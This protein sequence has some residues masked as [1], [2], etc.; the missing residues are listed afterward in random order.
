MNLRSGRASHLA[1][2]ALI[3]LSA[4]AALAYALSPGH[5][6]VTNCCV[7][8]DCSWSSGLVLA[9]LSLCLAGVAL[10]KVA[11]AVRLLALALSLIGLTGVLELVSFRIE[12]GRDGLLVR[13]AFTRR[14]VPW[15]RV[16]QARTSEDGHLALSDLD[17]R[18][19]EVD[20]WRLSPQQQ[21]ALT[22]TLARRIWENG[23]PAR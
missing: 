13:R 6:R 18:R 11:R 1:A 2:L 8:V 12:A 5:L 22:R 3:V 14:Q 10:F 15:N 20:L 9:L 23:R 4:A 21:G 7:V 17:G 16:A 19:L